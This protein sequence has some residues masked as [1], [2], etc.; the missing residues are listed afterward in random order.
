MDANRFKFFALVWIIP[1][2]WTFAQTNRYMVFFSDKDQVPFSIDA[3]ENFLSPKAI[4]RREK[5]DIAITGQ[6]LP[7]DR[8]YVELVNAAGADVFFTSRWFNA[9]LVQMDEGLLADLN[10]LTFVDSVSFIAPG[11]KLSLAQK[12]VEIPEVFTDPNPINA[13]SDVQLALLGVDEMHEDGYR[14]QGMTIAVFDDGFFGVNKFKPFEHLFNKERILGWKDFVENSGNVFRYDDHGSASL[15][16]IAAMHEQ[17]KGTAPEANYLLC[18]TED[19][20]NE[21]NWLL[22]AEYAD[23]A[24]VDII[25]SSLGYSTFDNQEMN[26]TYSDLNGKNTIITQAARL[27]ADRGILVVVSAGNEGNGSWK[28]ITAPADAQGVIAVG[29][30]G[31]TGTKSGFSSV[32]N[33]SDGRIKPDVVALGSF[34]T[35]FFSSTGDDGRISSGSGTSFAAPQ[36]AGFAAGVWQANPD[37]TNHEVMR[38]IKYSGNNALSPDSLVGFGLPSYRLAVQGALLSATD[39]LDDKITIFPNP[40][41]EDRFQ[42]D[43]GGMKLRDDLSISVVD[44]KGVVIYSSQISR[45]ELPDQLEINLSSSQQGVYFLILQ[46][47]K[48]KKTVK[49]IKI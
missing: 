38:A 42:I 23:S 6:D 24:G 11:A 34:T 22:A 16:C 28:Y 8:S 12:T 7:V 18:V 29:S 19:V 31:S 35:V 36:I 15:S 43:F 46:S 21:Y 47:K 39:I 3:P 40:F 17:M 13:N 41:N 45:K 37:W 20:K 32:G 25:S 4:E 48:I 44:M 33:T 1:F 9:A 26:Y 49:L 2:S 27:A 30:V 10:A 5:A 14:G